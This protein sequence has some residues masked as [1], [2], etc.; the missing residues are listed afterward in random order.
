MHLLIDI[1]NTRI[2]WATLSAAKLSL[3]R[4]MPR[5][6]WPLVSSQA[7]LLDLRE[8]PQSVL[9]ANVG[10]PAIAKHVADAVRNEWGLEPCFAQSTA[11]LAGVRNGYVTPEKLGVD[12]WMAVI[13]AYADVAHRSN[14]QRSPL[15]VVSVGTAMTIDGIRPS[16]DHLGGII[17]PGPDLMMQSLLQQTSD[18]AARART[19]ASEQGF[20]ARNTLSAIRQGA[21]HTLAATIERAMKVMAEQEA[22]MPSLIITGGA[23]EAVAAVMDGPYRLIPDLVLRG[24][25]VLATSDLVDE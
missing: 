7:S 10:G 9:I 14:N 11:A 16:G 18:I 20:F 21:V 2:K 25:A 1:G 13:A 24:L 12:R 23:S 15:C 17:V 6:D 5:A 3:Q 22:E 8:A 19:D 4:A